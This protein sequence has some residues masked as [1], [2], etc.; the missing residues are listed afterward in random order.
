MSLDRVKRSLSME[1]LHE[2]STTQGYKPWKSSSLKMDTLS[3]DRAFMASTVPRVEVTNNSVIIT[4]SIPEEMERRRRESM[5]AADLVEDFEKARRNSTKTEEVEKKRKGSPKGDMAQLF[6]KPDDDVTKDA[7]SQ[8][9]EVKSDPYTSEFQVWEEKP[10]LV[11]DALQPA[12]DRPNSTESTASH[13]KDEGLGESFDQYS[14]L[15][16]SLSR[17][18]N[19]A[20]SGEN[21]AS[22]KVKAGLS[23]APSQSAVVKDGEVKVASTPASRPPVNETQADV[24][25]SICSSKRVTFM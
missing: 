3:V 6:V 21:T 24:L 23:A 20:A 25:A 19:H 8:Q 14:E 4:E 22:E 11:S 12:G 1:P 15:S 13:K 16:D 18:G 17:N 5:K 9:Q 2:L 10:H 7:S